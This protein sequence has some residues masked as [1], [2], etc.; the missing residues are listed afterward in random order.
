[1]GVADHIDRHAHQL[2]REVAAV[3]E[4][5][6]AQKILVGL[7]VA[8]VLGDDHAGHRF[9]DFSRAQ[10]GA[11]G[12]LFGGD[13]AFASRIGDAVQV[14]GTAADGDFLQGGEAGGVGVAETGQGQ[15]DNC[16]VKQGE[17]HGRV[18]SNDHLHSRRWS[19]AIATQ[20]PGGTKQQAGLRAGES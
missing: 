10:Q 20:M 8:G 11:A 4:I 13:G 15:G 14:M 18:P 6:A 9:E 12:Q 2:R 19:I 1:M 7:A 5:E 3:V 17:F 16:W